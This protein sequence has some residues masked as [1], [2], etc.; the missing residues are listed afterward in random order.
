MRVFRKFFAAS[1]VRYLTTKR[2][3]PISRAP[4]D[5]ARG[6]L[7]KFGIQILHCRFGQRFTPTPASIRISVSGRDAQRPD[8]LIRLYHVCSKPRDLRRLIG[9]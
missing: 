6:L 7:V 9:V 1:I 5:D 8:G 2:N 3:Q 4:G